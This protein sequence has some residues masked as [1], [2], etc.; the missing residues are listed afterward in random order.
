M[1][2][3]ALHIID[4]CEAKIK[5]VYQDI[6]ADK[7]SH[8][9]EVIIWFQRSNNYGLPQKAQVQCVFNKWDDIHMY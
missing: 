6:H 2:H 3:Y 7:Y 1:S 5:K 9:Q 4:N 8:I